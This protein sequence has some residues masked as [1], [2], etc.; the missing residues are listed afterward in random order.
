MI[1]PNG[2]IA[3]S[4]CGLELLQAAGL[5]FLGKTYWPVVLLVLSGALAW[6]GFKQKCKSGRA[7][8]ANM[9]A[10]AADRDTAK[11]LKAKAFAEAFTARRI[12]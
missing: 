12:W 11:L 10:V 6:T 1:R 2:S 5:L 7:D 9:D 4:V 8:P 3:L